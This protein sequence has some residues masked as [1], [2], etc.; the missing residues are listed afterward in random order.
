MVSKKAARK[1]R[2]KMAKAGK[3]TSETR[4]YA[5]MGHDQKSWDKMEKIL[6]KAAASSRDRKHYTKMVHKKERRKL[7]K[8]M[9][10]KATKELPKDV[11]KAIQDFL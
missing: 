9:A 8:M 3:S 1:E 6:A 10:R 5:R 2:K 11:R 7:D 4:Q